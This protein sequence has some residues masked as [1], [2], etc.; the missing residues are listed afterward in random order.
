MVHC[1]S[2]AEGRHLEPWKPG[3]D[4]RIYLCDDY[5]CHKTEN[6]W[7][8]CWQCGYIRVVHGGGTT[9]IGQTPDTDLNEYVRD[10]YG[11]KESALLLEKMRGGQ[12]VPSL[13]HEECMT[14]VLEVLSNP[15][16]HIRASE[17]FKR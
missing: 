14:V 8:Y 3:R 2:G 16:L 13:S 7:N 17:G 10:K 15:A 9:P 5:K 1:Y 6:V 11:A 4:W 12:V